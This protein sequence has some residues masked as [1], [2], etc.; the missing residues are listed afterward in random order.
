MGDR[1]SGVPPILSQAAVGVVILL[2]IVI[3]KWLLGYIL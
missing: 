1:G 3:V 2:A